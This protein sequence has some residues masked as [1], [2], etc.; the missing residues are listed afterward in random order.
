MVGE[1]NVNPDALSRSHPSFSFTTV[2]A[3]ELSPDSF[4]MEIDAEIGALV[5]LYKHLATEL[6]KSKL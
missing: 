2:V 5:K 3:I 4:R 6:F 1:E